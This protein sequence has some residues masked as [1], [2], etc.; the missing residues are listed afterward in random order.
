M[1]TDVKSMVGSVSTQLAALSDD[2][3]AL[4]MARYM[5]TSMPFYGVLKSDWTPIAK[6]LVKLF[7]VTDKRSYD[8]AVRAL[9]RLPHREEKYVAIFVAR[10]FAH[11]VNGGSLKLYEQMIRSGAWWDFVDEIAI[12]LVGKVVGT[13]RE[14]FLLLD[15]WL[16]DKNLWIRRTA[17]IAQLNFKET[18]DTDRLSHYCL[19]RAR[20]TEFFIRKAIGWALR[21]Y[22]YTQPDW[23]MEFL[24]CHQPVLS[25]LSYREAAKG[26]RRNGYDI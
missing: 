18:T 2:D 15:Q 13:E 26:L 24:R 14:Q 21:Q 5:K 25:G 12:H 10:H 1:A 20:E 3:K 22:S 7:P 16:D 6:R 8:A 23:V 17:L 19:T 4:Q 11:Y 9:W